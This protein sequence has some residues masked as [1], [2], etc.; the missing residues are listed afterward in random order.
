MAGFGGS[1]AAANHAMKTNRAMLGKRKKGTLSFISSKNEHWVDPN[2][3]TSQ[4]LLEIRTRIRKEEKVR[5]KKIMTLTVIALIAV[6]L[7][8]L[9]LS[10]S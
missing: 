4:Q 3:P 5:H 1:V 8:I 9:Y 6:I 10:G 2:Q 7:G